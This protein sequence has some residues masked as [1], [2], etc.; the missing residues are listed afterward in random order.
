MLADQLIKADRKD[1]AIE[2]LQL[3]HERY[4]GEGRDSD[5]AAVGGADAVDRPERRAAVVGRRPPKASSAD[6]IFID[7]DRLRHG[8]YTRPYAASPAACAGTETSARSR[9]GARARLDVSAVSILQIRIRAGST[10]D[11]AE[12]S[13]RLLRF[14]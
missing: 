14:R 12:R 10:E 11:V 9:A 6:L 5:A 4:D 2:Q 1:E 3:L 13:N 8:S 7:L